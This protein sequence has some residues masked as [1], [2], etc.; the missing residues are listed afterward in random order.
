MFRKKVIGYSPTAA[1]AR[2]ARLAKDADAEIEAL[3]LRLRLLRLRRSA[4]LLQPNSEEIRRLRAKISHLKRGKASR[5]PEHQLSTD[6]LKA[7]A[8]FGNL[9]TA[10]LAKRVDPVR[11]A[12]IKRAVTKYYGVE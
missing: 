4:R 8:K 1:R 5:P 10:R 7:A 6:A 3:E 11:A 12:V 9:K 2:R